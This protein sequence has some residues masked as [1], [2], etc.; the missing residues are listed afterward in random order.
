MRSG[1]SHDESFVEF[2]EHSRRS[3]SGTA[4]FLTGDK[5]DADD[6][7]QTAYLR[8]Y[9]AW[10]R[11]RR[12]DATAY[13]R[14]VLVNLAIDRWRAPT[15]VPVDQDWRAD[16]SDAHASSDDRDHLRRLLD[17]LPPRQRAVVVLR[18]YADLSEA[19]VATELDISVG[20]VKS[21]ASRGL[22]ALRALS[23]QKE[24]HHA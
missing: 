9:R 23:E 5:D 2:V 18:Y 16:P 6:L 20:A 4:W 1:S 12:D 7:L 13:T 24:P 3:L 11:V 8:T 14:K 22:A 21:A 15:E 10:R 17:S 19:D